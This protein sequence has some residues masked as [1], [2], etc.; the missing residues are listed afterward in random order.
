[1]SDSSDSEFDDL[2]AAINS[3][4]NGAEGGDQSSEVESEK[5]EKAKRRKLNSAE[6]TDLDKFLFGDKSE[7][8]RNL[9]DNKLFFSDVAGNVEENQPQQSL[10]HDSDDEDHSKSTVGG[11]YKKFKRLAG[12]DP[13]WAQLGGKKEEEDSDDEG[14]ISRK[15]GHIHTSQGSSKALTQGELSF[16]RLTNVNKA[17]MKEGRITSVKFH[18]KSTVGI[19]AGLKGM[20]SIFSIDGRDNKK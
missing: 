16:K 14:E 3:I 5:T 9:E 11:E 10:W 13:S 18:P 2:A 1:M 12:S 7:L 19:V 15:I 17:T 6:K 20:V 8:I 4:D